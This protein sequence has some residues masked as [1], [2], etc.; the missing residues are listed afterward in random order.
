MN[1]VRT[2][3]SLFLVLA[4]VSA[5]G[6]VLAQESETPSDEEMKALLDEGVALYNDNV[7]Q[8]DVSFA[9]S[10]IA[11]KTVNVY[12]DDG[13][14]TH[15]FSAS[16]EDDMTI[17][18]VATGPN[19]DASTR[20]STDRQTLEAIAASSDPLGEVEQA[21]RD[22]RIRVSGEKGHLVDQAVWTV[23]NVFKGFLL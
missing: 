8:L 16:V 5:S 14:E 21:V 6:P 20:I 18:N 3:V 12:I 1:S 13:G 2:L 4:L 22:D 7:D 9:R 19:A 11:G 10:L 15:V 23:A 17:S